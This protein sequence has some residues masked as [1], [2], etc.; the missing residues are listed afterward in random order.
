MKMI[1]KKITAVMT[2]VVLFAACI[3][4]DTPEKAAAA[5]DTDVHKPH[6]VCVNADNCIDCA[7]TDVEWTEW[8]SGNSLPKT[9]GNYYLTQDVTVKYDTTISSGQEVSLCLNGHTV[10]MTQNNRIYNV[11]AGGT[12]NL[13]NCKSSGSLTGGGSNAVLVYG[14]FNMYSGTITGFTPTANGGVFLYENC[15]FTMAGGKISNN[16]SQNGTGGGVYVN[17]NC[18]FTMTGGTISEN[19]A[20]RG[21]GG[22]Y[23]KGTFTMIDGTISKNTSS[24]RNGGGVEGSGGTITME[25]GRISENNALWSGGGV[26]ISD[27][28]FI[29]SGGEII[30]NKSTQKDG[31]GIFLE[32][33]STFKMT[34]GTISDN[35]SA[36]NGGGISIFDDSVL[37]MSGGKIIS[38]TAAEDGGGAYI[39]TGKFTMTGGT[40][41]KNTAEKGGGVQ[42]IYYYG[43]DNQF[44]MSGS[45]C[46]ISENT[47]NSYGG[48]V[49][50]EATF[51]MTDAVISGNTVTNG[52]GGGVC[53][54]YGGIFSMTGGKIIS[55]T[56]TDGGGVYLNENAQFTMTGGSISEN[57][58]A[59]KGGGV[60]HGA[61]DTYGK[62][63]IDGKSDISSNKKSDDS[64]SNAYLENKTVVTIG[65][66]F[67][68]ESNI[69]VTAYTA[70]T[71]SRS[72]K[73]SDAFDTDISEGFSSDIPEYSVAY[74]NNILNL[75]KAHSYL[76]EHDNDSHWGKCTVCN[77]AMKTTPHEWNDGEIT[78]AA[79]CTEDGEK[80]YICSVCNADKTEDVPATGHSFAAD[81][82]SNETHHWHTATC[83]HTSEVSDEAEHTWDDGEI[84]QEPTCTAKGVKT[85]TCDVCGAARTEDV[86][87]AGHAFSDEW[88]SSETHHWHAAICG[89]TNEVSDKAEHIWGAG[90][91]DSITGDII[92]TCSVCQAIKTDKHTH[93]FSDEWSSDEAN[94]WHAAA[95]GHT[96]EVSDKAAHTWN[97]GEIT[98]PATETT[99]GVKTYTCTACGRTRTETITKL[100]HTHVPS[101]EWTSDPAGHWHSCSG[102]TEKLDFSAHTEDGGAVTVQPA[103]TTAGTKTFKCTVC[104]YVMRTETIPATGG[105]FGGSGGT[106]RPSRP[107]HTKPDDNGSITEK[108]QPGANVPETTITT[109]LDELADIVLTPA[110]KA[111]VNDGTDIIII[112]T[113]ED[114]TYLVP[115]ADKAMVE[116][117]IGGMQGCK[118]GQYLDVNLL[119]IIG[120][121]QKKIHETNALITVM[122]EI[123]EALRGDGREYAVIRV[124]D[125]ETAVLPD[126]DK[127]ADTVTIQSDKFST[128]ALVYSEETESG[129]SD[130]S[131]S[132]SGEPAPET[133]ETAESR[134]ASSESGG[135]SSEVDGIVTGDET[136]LTGES[137][138]FSGDSAGSGESEPS[139]SPEDSSPDDSDPVPG[140]SSPAEGNSNP[141]TGI[142][143]TLVP[144]ATALAAVAVSVKRRRK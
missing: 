14:A 79:T 81:W 71:C 89:D 112:L 84:T 24:E 61:T 88:T 70:P 72:V 82:A 36:T 38:N 74:Q 126:L 25:G 10:T 123:P 3:V 2:A 78:K 33:N 48:G 50:N 41:S 95:C 64:A 44:S 56:A 77:A 40:V 45:N 91:T 142:A 47:A 125:G 66:G 115:A 18:T 27:G 13:C 98:T 54:W 23:N 11:S 105:G 127:D 67:N 37:E 35:T 93:T 117:V 118:L 94:H 137:G 130:E 43:H 7:H 92:Y 138:T 30:K 57:T 134:E 69:G 34:D 51:T 144:L 139:E 28:K 68:T 132:D 29:M 116:A 76:F 32:V 111:E 87:A 17:E 140:E 135:G 80:L 9:T 62:F 60:Y 86:E 16:T 55:N 5:A 107:S 46:I 121:V 85:Y 100:Q 63:T 109:S 96:S 22:V 104:G 108:V 141:S 39:H 42:C 8:T 83:I 26:C 97:D 131:S 75:I 49:C 20:P 53:N 15:T 4:F 143:V 99:D 90:V 6:K 124:H 120:S 103:E 128:Y 1:L 119:K 136:S 106:A 110:E 122:F 101:G 113:I 129:A 12:L 102:C 114:G 73:I 52:N 21:G 58:A 31:G 65:S 59:A 19:T 133:S